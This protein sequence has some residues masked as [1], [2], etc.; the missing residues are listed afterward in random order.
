MFCTVE[1]NIIT[2]VIVCSQEFAL[3]RGLKE[4]PE[5]KGIGDPYIDVPQYTAVWDE[6]ATAYKEGVQDA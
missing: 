6:M 4:L 1:N 5:G 2:N 3:S